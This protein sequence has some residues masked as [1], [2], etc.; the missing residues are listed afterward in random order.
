MPDPLHIDIPFENKNQDRGFYSRHSLANGFTLDNLNEKQQHLEQRLQQTISKIEQDYLRSCKESPKGITRHN[1]SGATLILLMVCTLENGESYYKSFSI[2]DSGAYI[3]SREIAP[4]P[5]KRQQTTLTFES[6]SDLHTL[7][8]AKELNRIGELKRGENI[9]N[10]QGTCDLLGDGAA[11]DLSLSIEDYKNF[12]KETHNYEETISQVFTERILRDPQISDSCTRLYNLGKRF[13]TCLRISED[14]CNAIEHHIAGAYPYDG[15]IRY[16]KELI[17]DLRSLTARINIPHQNC[18]TPTKSFGDKVNNNTPQVNPAQFDCRPWTHL[19]KYQDQD[20]LIGLASDGFRPVDL[21]TSRTQIKKTYISTSDPAM[22]I[23]EFLNFLILKRDRLR[24]KDDLLLYG[25]SIQDLQ[26]QHKGKL[27]CMTVCDGHG[28]LGDQAAECLRNGLQQHMPNILQT[29]YGI[30]TQ[31]L[32]AKEHNEP[33]EAMGLTGSTGTNAGV[34]TPLTG[35]ADPRTASQNT[36]GPKTPHP[37][38]GNPTAKGTSQAASPTC[39][40]VPGC[41]IS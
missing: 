9:V 34:F 5:R 6:I 8:N 39:A 36:T 20:S 16:F 22:P 35:G 28:A 33:S 41:C 11:Y 21:F 3:V 1:I 38:V 19:Q 31:D 18:T 10:L 37:A 40:S 30:T 14:L 7:H 29:V 25:L 23:E 24:R 13:P 4:L 2:G 26:Q 32:C 12:L 17:K 27:T 15:D